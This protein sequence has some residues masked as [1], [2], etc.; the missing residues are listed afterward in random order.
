MGV[1]VP[2][3][4]FLVPVGA[5]YE[6]YS[7]EPRDGPPPAAPEPAGPSRGWIAAVRHWLARKLSEAVA[8]QRLLW[9]LRHQVTCNLVH[10]GN[11]TGHEAV[12]QLRIA[13][14]RDRKRHRRWLF[15]DGLLLIASIPLTLIPGPNVAGL[16]FGARVVGHW[17]SL[18]GCRQGL[19]RIE[20]RP[21]S[22]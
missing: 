13:L 4:V 5:R 17:F 20:W 11:I 1:R 12:G 14:Q 21:R 19:G 18:R 2:M 22:L 9:E 3:D 8:E 6:L 15:I 7:S 10:P 16:Y